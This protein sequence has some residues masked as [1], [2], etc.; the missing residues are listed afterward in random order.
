MLT[1]IETRILRVSVHLSVNVLSYYFRYYCNDFGS[2][3]CRQDLTRVLG[4]LSEGPRLPWTRFENPPENNRVP[5]VESQ[6]RRCL[7]REE[8]Q[9]LLEQRPPGPTEGVY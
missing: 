8:K 2:P 5:R 9:G 4:I 7:T 1:R 3:P 6:R